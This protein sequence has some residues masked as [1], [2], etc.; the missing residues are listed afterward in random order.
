MTSDFDRLI[1]ARLSPATMP[2]LDQD[3]HDALYSYYATDVHEL[4]E[5]LDRRLPGWPMERSTV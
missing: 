5:L 1:L 4:E 2:V 3:V